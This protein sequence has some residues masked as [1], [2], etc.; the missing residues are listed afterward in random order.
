MVFGFGGKE[1]VSIEF[2]KQ[3]AEIIQGEKEEKDAW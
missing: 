3:L 2:H 1:G